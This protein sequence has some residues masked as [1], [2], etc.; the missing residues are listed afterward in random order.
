MMPLVRPNS[1]AIDYTPQG[2]KHSLTGVLWLV[3]DMSCPEHGTWQGYSTMLLRE[4]ALTAQQV[5]DLPE[6]VRVALLDRV[7]QIRIR[8]EEHAP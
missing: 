8:A 4:G 5:R 1:I 3:W 2:G 7:R 6:P